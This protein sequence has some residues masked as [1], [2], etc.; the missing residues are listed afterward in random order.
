MQQQGSGPRSLF[1]AMA[2]RLHADRGA[3]MRDGKG[4]RRQ[5]S[6]RVAHGRG[7]AELRGSRAGLSIVVEADERFFCA[8]SGRL[9]TEPVRHSSGI[10]C[11]RVSL[12][13]WFTA[14]AFPGALRQL[15]CVGGVSLSAKRRPRP[16]GGPRLCTTLAQ[17]SRQAR[18]LF[19]LW[20][21]ACCS[22]QMS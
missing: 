16:C 17:H 18:A 19:E 7:R 6:F 20:Q 21:H 13:D 12:N 11:D 15:H 14:G 10:V 2:P 4:A 5:V 1:A 22:A 9:M 8:M 3:A